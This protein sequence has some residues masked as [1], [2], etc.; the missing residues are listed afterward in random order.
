MRSEMLLLPHRER[1][2]SLQGAAGVREASRW[3]SWSPVRWL[4]SAAPTP[5]PLQQDTRPGFY[6][7]LPSPHPDPTGVGGGC[8]R[9][10]PVSWHGWRGMGGMGSDTPPPQGSLDRELPPI[11]SAPLLANSHFLEVWSLPAPASPSRALLPSTTEH[12]LCARHDAQGWAH[13][14]GPAR[15]RP[16]ASIQSRAMCGTG[17]EVTV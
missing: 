16:W 8:E 11:A 3:A 7:L 17:N 12:L 15:Q 4:G 6:P 9:G 2:S 5:D 10:E 1:P 14:G 13:T